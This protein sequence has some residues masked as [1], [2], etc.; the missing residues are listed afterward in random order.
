MEDFI[1][2]FIELNNLDDTLQLNNQH[3]A[4]SIS[5]R[6]GISQCWLVRDG[7]RWNVAAYIPHWVFDQDRPEING[8]KLAVPAHVWDWIDHS[9]LL[10]RLIG[11]NQSS[12]EINH[13][14]LPVV[15]PSEF[16]FVVVH[17]YFETS[18]TVW[19]H[20]EKKSVDELSEHTFWPVGHACLFSDSMLI[21]NPNVGGAASVGTHPTSAARMIGLTDPI[22]VGDS[23]KLVIHDGKPFAIVGRSRTNHSHVIGL[24]VEWILNLLAS[25]EIVFAKQYFANGASITNHDRWSRLCHILSN[26]HVASSVFDWSI[27]EPCSGHWLASIPADA[28]WNIG[29]LIV[30]AGGL[31]IF[32][33]SCGRGLKAYAQSERGTFCVQ[34]VR[35]TGA[36]AD[37]ENFGA[38]IGNVV[39]R[40]LEAFQAVLPTPNTNDP[41]E[42][43]DQVG[44]IDVENH[45]G[46]GGEIVNN[47]DNLD[48]V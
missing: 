39:T 29:Y 22:E 35:T 16:D 44:E 6:K 8:V 32:L 47:N 26:L 2:R 28:L 7:H 48:T 23:G 3:I 30:V 21:P 27:C 12:V 15:L 46:D 14:D 38:Q 41:E 25:Q 19:D 42:T 18:I 17:A 45:G 11:A 4:T 24:Q 40:L 5:I 34:I 9:T 1:R 31:S 13:F 10:P 43:Q 37:L 33:K 20:F 36:G